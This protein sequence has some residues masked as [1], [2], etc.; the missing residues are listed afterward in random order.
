M[1]LPE[2]LRLKIEQE[3]LYHTKYGQPKPKTLSE[4]KYESYKAGATY[5]ALQVEELRKEN[6][7]LRR[8]LNWI[9]KCLEQGLP[10]VDIID[11]I[12]KALAGDGGSDE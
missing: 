3:A 5:Y 6:D 1:Q 2:E 4:C 11:F 8:K 9:K 10:T 12:S 7:L